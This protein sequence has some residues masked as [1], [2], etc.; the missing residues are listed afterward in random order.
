MRLAHKLQLHDTFNT[1][2]FLHLTFSFHSNRS[3]NRAISIDLA[4]TDNYDVTNAKPLTL[5]L[6][7]ASVNL[8]VYFKRKH[9][10]E[11]LF[12]SIR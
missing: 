3:S 2:T 12:E 6:L 8:C 4:V 5:F 1:D 11:I 7:F 10:Y 9:E